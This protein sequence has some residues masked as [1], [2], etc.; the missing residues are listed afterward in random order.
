MPLLYVLIAHCQK[1]WHKPL[2]LTKSISISSNTHKTRLF[3]AT[4]RLYQLTSSNSWLS[5][6]KSEATTSVRSRVK[7]NY[8]KSTFS[9]SSRTSPH[10]SNYFLNHFRSSPSYLLGLLQAADNDLPLILSKVSDARRTFFD[11]IVQVED[12]LSFRH[13][14]AWPDHRRLDRIFADQILLP[15][16][17]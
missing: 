9:L 15:P 5:V 11:D 17:Q 2:R 3:H 10:L 16:P 8:D 14:F 4:A 7:I 13:H 12:L 6:L 1:G